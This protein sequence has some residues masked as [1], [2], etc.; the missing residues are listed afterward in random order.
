M[1]CTNCGK[2]MNDN[3]AVC[4]EC[5]V[6]KGEGNSYCPNC[7][8]PV[9]S[10]QVICVKCG[11]SLKRSGSVS[12]ND[13][14]LPEGKDKITA[15]VLAFFLGS[16]GIHNFYL[17]ENKKGV[18]KIIATLCCG[19]GFILALIDFIKLLFGSYKFNPDAMI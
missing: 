12:L 5:G 14:G 1:Y 18:V 4:L 17:G 2:P 15:A 8:E 3:Q 7:G 6:K 19:I 9:A 13:D 11:V 16:L 10:N